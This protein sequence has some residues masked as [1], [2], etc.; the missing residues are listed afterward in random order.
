MIVILES[1]I[2]DKIDISRINELMSSGIVTY[3]PLKSVLQNEYTYLDVI[4]KY[5]FD[6]KVYFGEFNDTSKSCSMYTLDCDGKNFDLETPFRDILVSAIKDKA[7][8]NAVAANLLS[9]CNN[10]EEVKQK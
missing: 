6:N 8:Q 7:K 1:T 3:A 5:M 4:N 9:T 2:N 10:Y